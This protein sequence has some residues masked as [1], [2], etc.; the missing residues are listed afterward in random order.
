MSGHIYIVTNRKNGALYTG[1][2]ADPP[3]RIAEHRDGTGSG[4]AR[5]WGICL[6]VHVEQHD[7]IE[8]VVFAERPEDGPP[9]SRG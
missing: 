5:K 1:V 3:R 2:T 7:R 6:L 8:D 9:L 4:F